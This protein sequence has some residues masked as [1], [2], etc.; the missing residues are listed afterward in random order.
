M[1]IHIRLDEL[2]QEHHLTAKQLSE[3]TGITEAAISEWR[4]NKV[5]R[6]SLKTLNTLCQALNCEPGDLIVKS[7]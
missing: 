3:Q 6:I 1:T 5:V 4:T 2:M 7:R